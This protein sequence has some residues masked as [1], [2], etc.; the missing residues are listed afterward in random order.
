MAVAVFTNNRVGHKQHHRLRYVYQQT[1][2]AISK[3]QWQGYDILVLIPALHTSLARA[4]AEACIMYRPNV[5]QCR[6]LL[7]TLSLGPISICTAPS[8]QGFR[9][10]LVCCL[11]PHV[12]CTLINTWTL[13]GLCI[14]LRSL[15]GLP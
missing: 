14:S 8:Q 1:E 13:T 5:F 3:D 9:Y 15:V 7:V 4:S 2:I 6:A 11:I 10:F 12:I